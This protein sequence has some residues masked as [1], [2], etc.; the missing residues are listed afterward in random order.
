MEVVTLPVGEVQMWENNARI[1]TR[2][3]LEAL[4]GSLKKFTQLKPII[5]QKSSMRIIAGNGTYAAICALGGE[6]V[7]CNIVDMSDADAKAYAIADNRTALLSEWDEKT[8]TDTLKEI[9]LDGNLEL[10]G[11]DTI[12][13]E[14]MISFQDGGMF[15]RLTPDNKVKPP[16]PQ[17]AEEAPPP[18]V[19]PP[20]ELEQPSDPPERA[21]APYSAQITFTVNGFVFALDDPSEIEEIQCLTEL[22]KEAETPVRAEVNSEVFQAIKQILTNRFMR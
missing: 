1:H 9:Q 11:F 8:L 6:T 18:P 19:E 12:D 4:K 22:L 14:K 3:N 17:K 15:D 2:K 10:T 5:V 7:D 16:K 20:K 13:L 21:S